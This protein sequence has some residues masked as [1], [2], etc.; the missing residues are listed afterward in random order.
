MPPII[1]TL[2][3]NEMEVLKNTLETFHKLGF[4][5]EE[6]GGNEYALRSVPVDLYGCN[7]KEMFIEVLDE[8]VEGG[9]RTN[10]KVIEEKLASMSCKTT[11]KGNNL[12]S[13]RGMEVLID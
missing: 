4:E 1:L 13:L 10:L 6:F 9:I 5:V 12:L 2:T 3:G 7:E 11:I 8:L